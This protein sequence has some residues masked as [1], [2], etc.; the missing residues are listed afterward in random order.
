MMIPKPLTGLR[1]L[2]LVCIALFYLS[3]AFAGE[4]AE[5]AVQKHH[6]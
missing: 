1:G 2:L 6:G 3:L 4:E 5:A